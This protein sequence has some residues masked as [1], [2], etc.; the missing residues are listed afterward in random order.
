VRLAPHA[1]WRSR[2]LQQC[3]N[4]ALQLH[5][6]LPDVLGCVRQLNSMLDIHSGD[7]CCQRL[8]V[9]AS[10]CKGQGVG[11]LWHC[12]GHLPVM[13]TASSESL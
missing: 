8:L 4:T 13:L 5:C 2:N 1:G 7:T 9:S 12:T 11:V 6:R 3:I 10:A